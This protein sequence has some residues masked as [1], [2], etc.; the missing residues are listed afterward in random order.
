M[1][2]RPV[3]LAAAAALTGAVGTLLTGL[4]AGMGGGDVAH[5][6]LLMLPAVAVTVVTATAARPLLARATFRQRL[7]TIGAVAV[8][9]SLANLGALAA[10]MFISAHDALLMGTLLLYSAG[11]GIGAAL[12]L[13][14]SSA[15]ALEH[16]VR[17]ARRLGSG[18]LQA[19]VGPLGGGPE[20]EALGRA[21]DD[22]VDRLQASLER[23]R[24]VEARRRDLVTAVSHDLRTPLAGL[25]AMVEAIDEGVVEDPSVIRRYAAEMGRSVASLSQLVDDLFELTQLD[26]GAIEAESG[27]SRLDEVVRSAIAACEVQA[28]EKGLAVETALDGAAS[29]WCSPRLVRVLQN[30]LQN[31][32]RHTPTDGVVRI[33]GHPRPDGIEVTV[34]DTGVGIPPEDL[35]RV[36]EPFWRGE[37]ARGG[38]G[39]GLGLTLARRIVEALGGR[40]SVE[41]A[42]DRGS[43]FVVTLPFAERSG[44]GRSG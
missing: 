4:A 2:W 40:I 32:I 9:V 41:S 33:E 36:F 17:T 43:R 39:S 27:R 28:A 10:L 18:D 12:A 42:P 38:D 23:E 19:R 3:L 34:E 7:V 13:S 8:V 6:V 24:A 30:L 21:L 29:S 15:A 16:V 20:L 1:S 25:R 26:A 31:A 5:L 35:D 44:P 11:A 22:M 14:R 37:P